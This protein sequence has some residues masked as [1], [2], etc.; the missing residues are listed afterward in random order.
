MSINSTIVAIVISSSIL[1]ILIL[2]PH[3][4]TVLRH[5]MKKTNF[6]QLGQSSQIRLIHQL[7]DAVEQLSSTKTGSLI[8][9]VNKTNLEHFRTDGVIIDAN[10]SASLIIS[11][12]NKYSP[13]HD[14]AIIIQNG[15]ITY[16]STYFKITS[17]S[18]DNRLGARHRAALGISE[19][20]DA[21]TIVVSETNGDISFAKAGIL[22]KVSTAEFQEKLVEAIK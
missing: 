11:I 1:A 21:L 18:V 17:K 15:K 12:F 4:I 9:L 10:I 5:V 22:T 20:T 8:T 2:M 16:A 13:L 7:Y 14:G 6:R 19:Q 3:I